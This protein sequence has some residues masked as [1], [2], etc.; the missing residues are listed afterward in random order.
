M[1]LKKA[2]DDMK[3]F[4]TEKTFDKKL[5]AFN[6]LKNV[7]NFIVTAGETIYF[8]AIKNIEEKT[9]LIYCPKYKFKKNDKIIDE[10]N[11]QYFVETVDL[12]FPYNIIVDDINIEVSL[13]KIVYTAK[14]QELPSYLNK[15]EIHSN[16]QIQAT[17][18]TFGNVGEFLINQK[19]DYMSIFNDIEN[20]VNN[21]YYIEKLKPMVKIISDDIKK[22]KEI[23]ESNLRKFFKFMGTQLIELIRLFVAAY[24]YGLSQK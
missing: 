19:L 9:L 4:V 22:K 24:A 12:N 11:V 5:I 21:S 23:K 1:E 6:K 7:Y 13:Q 14:P 10:S 2:L 3:S 20:I 17:G 8:T 15:A 18:S 16:I